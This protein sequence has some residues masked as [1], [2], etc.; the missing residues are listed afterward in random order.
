MPMDIIFLLTCSA[1]FVNSYI[2]QNHIS[3][4]D[5]NEGCTWLQ[6]CVLMSMI[7]GRKVLDGISHKTNVSL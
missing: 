2:S 1:H 5:V 6:Y 4:P 7:E 3:D